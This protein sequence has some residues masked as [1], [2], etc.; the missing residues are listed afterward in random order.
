M[1]TNFKCF[2]TLGN[3][4]RTVSSNWTKYVLIVLTAGFFI[5]T[6]AC[7][8]EHDNKGIMVNLVNDSSYDFQD[9]NFQGVKYGDIKSKATSK[10][11]R[12][13]K[14]YLDL[15]YVKLYI[16]GKEFVIQPIDFD[17]P[18]LSVGDCTYSIKVENYNERRLSI[19]TLLKH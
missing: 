1:N 17:A 12:F 14:V 18:E 6:T 4:F 10:S 11:I 13:D 19:T 16:D 5:G 15:A 8:K 9:V 7:K 2:S 3:K